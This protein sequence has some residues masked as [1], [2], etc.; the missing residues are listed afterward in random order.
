MVEVHT[1]D[2][3][4]KEERGA[5]W[6]EVAL[7]GVRRDSP[8]HWGT[9]EQCGD[10]VQGSRSPG[11]GKKPPEGTMA[12]SFGDVPSQAMEFR[13]ERPS[14]EGS[15]FDTPCALAPQSRAAGNAVTRRPRSVAQD[16]DLGCATPHLSDLT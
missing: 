2:S 13:G 10:K 14:E 15:V 6:W 1:E 5:G 16:S 4:L 11:K 3:L 7:E 12:V 8:F 9:Y